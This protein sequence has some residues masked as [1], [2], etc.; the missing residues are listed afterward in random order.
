M[1]ILP[2]QL[3]ENRAQ[4]ALDRGDIDAAA[5]NDAQLPRRGR[6]RFFVVHASVVQPIARAADRE[7]LLVQELPNAADEQDLVVL[8]V[9][10]VA[11]PL[12]GLQLGELLL[13]VAQ[14]V[15]LDAAQLAHLADGE[16]ALRRNRRELSF[17]A[18]WLH[19]APSR[20]SP[21][22]SGWHGR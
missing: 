12:H 7:A 1:R 19:D 4:L 2:L 11:A 20:P 15:R 21:S 8:V 17:P 14:H 18:T 6:L 10:A 13:P 3:V 5:R 16:V 22:V 9:A